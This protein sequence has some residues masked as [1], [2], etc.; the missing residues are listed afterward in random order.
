MQIFPV[1]TIAA[2]FRIAI[3]VGLWFHRESRVQKYIRNGS[4]SAFKN[5]KCLIKS[6]FEPEEVK[7]VN[8]I[9]ILRSPSLILIMKEGN[10]LKIL[11]RTFVKTVVKSSRLVKNKQVF[12][13]NS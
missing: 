12:E 5:K 7:A 8:Q 13:F 3:N 4:V 11:F 9:S 6:A 10:G 2:F 1:Y